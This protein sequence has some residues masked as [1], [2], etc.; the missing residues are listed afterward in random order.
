VNSVSIL[1]WSRQ[2]RNTMFNALVV[3]NIVLAGFGDI[4]LLDLDTIDLSNLNRQF[5][6]RK[7]D[8]KQSKALVAAKTAS[9][10]N[11]SVKIT[12]L[13]AN[14]KEATFDAQWFAGFHIVMSALDNL[15]ARRHINRMC[16]ASGVPLIES[17]TEGYFGQVQPIIQ[18][19][20]NDALR[21]ITAEIMP[22]IDQSVMSVFQSLYNNAHILC[23]L[24]DPHRRS[25]FIA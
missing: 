10:F 7:K 14:I 25:L 13:C 2:I 21:A 22:R 3:K 9:A 11:P 23:V 1:S 24:S 16:L 19:R 20:S 6:F 8:V 4:T 18:V 15:D 5:L 12:P 17:G